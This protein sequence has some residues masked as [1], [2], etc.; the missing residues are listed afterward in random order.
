MHINFAPRRPAAL[1]LFG[2]QF[3]ERDDPIHALLVLTEPGRSLDDDTVGIPPAS[4]SR[5]TIAGFGY[6]L[7]IP[8]GGSASVATK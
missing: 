7:A 1:L 3:E 4:G 8:S 2:N 5:L 6:H